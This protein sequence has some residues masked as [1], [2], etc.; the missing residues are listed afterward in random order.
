MVPDNPTDKHHDVTSLDD[1]MGD[2]DTPT[3]I[4]EVVEEAPVV[5]PSDLMV[6]PIDE[7]EILEQHDAMTVDDNRGGQRP[8]AV[9]FA[10]IAGFETHPSMSQDE[11]EEVAMN[12]SGFDVDLNSAVEKYGGVIDKIIRGFFMATFGTTTASKEDP[13]LAV[14][15]A[16]E[17][18]EVAE[19]HG[20]HIHVGV[21][22]G[23]AWVGQIRTE[24]TIDTTVIGDTINLS[25]RLKTQAP[26]NGVCV[27]PDAYESTKEYF[28]Y[29]VLRELPPG[30]L[31]GIERPM[32]VYKPLAKTAK[33][34]LV[35]TV[36]GSDE[37]RLKLLEESIPEYLKEKIKEG[38]SRL[39]GERKMVTLLY[40]DVSGFTALSEKF[41]TQPELIAEVMNRCHKRLGDIVYK[42]EGVV[43]KLVGDEIMAIF[44]APIMHEDDPERAVW[45]ALEMMEEMDRLSIEVQE[46]FKVPPLSV[47]IGINTGRVS[48][49]NLKPG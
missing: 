2:S 16:M 45:C 42:H 7:E 35:T 34:D 22:S 21:N 47:H 14:L 17:M 18:C 40:S 44:G 10:S 19:K 32:T 46:E 39:Q 12:K 29:E 27:S 6:S 3:A 25:A 33:A 8:V 37:E 38:A 4:E 36:R 41:A 5:D 13:V 49:G 28:E 1:L 15:T 43:D 9:I 26:D 11:I 48:I 30:T 31:K 20:A 24:R 23:N